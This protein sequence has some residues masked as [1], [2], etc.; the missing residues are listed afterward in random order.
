M[1]EIENISFFFL[2]PRKVNS[3][4]M[5]YLHVLAFTVL[6]LFPYFFIVLRQLAK[7]PRLY[8][9]GSFSW[10]NYKQIFITNML[11]PFI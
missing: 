9:K 11:F 2:S 4:E 8:F 1:K 10:K 5:S 3:F 6:F 7:K